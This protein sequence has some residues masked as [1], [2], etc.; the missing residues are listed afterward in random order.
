MAIDRRG[1]DMMGYPLKRQLKNYTDL[2]IEAA[3]VLAKEAGYEWDCVYTDPAVTGKRFLKSARIV[4]Q[5]LEDQAMLHL[6][7][8]KKLL[9]E[10]MPLLEDQGYLPEVRKIRAVLKEIETIK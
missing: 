8:A 6:E 7:A 10:V 1:K 5:F 4:R 2:D 9:K 3:R